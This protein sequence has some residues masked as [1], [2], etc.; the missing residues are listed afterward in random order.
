MV[1]GARDQGWKPRT[2]CS[3]RWKGPRPE[4]ASPRPKTCRRWGGEKEPASISTHLSTHQHSGI[5]ERRQLR[6]GLEVGGR[7]R[8]KNKNKNKNRGEQSWK[9]KTAADPRGDFRI[10]LCRGRPV[11]EAGRER[12][13]AA[14]QKP[15]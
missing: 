6:R 11:R 2:W 10:A 9:R 5:A 3:Q 7:N 1:V 4:R 13:G 8:T 12:A 15:S 14:L